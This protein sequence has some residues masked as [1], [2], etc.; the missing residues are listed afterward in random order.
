MIIYDCLWDRLKFKIRKT[1]TLIIGNRTALHVSELSYV[2]RSPNS[3][4]LK[5]R[6]LFPLYYG[7]HF[8][9]YSSPVNE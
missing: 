1:R 5:A 7:V 6:R 4:T 2:G 9:D 3:V 8:R